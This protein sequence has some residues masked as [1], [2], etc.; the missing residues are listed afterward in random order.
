MKFS[1]RSAAGFSPS[2][3]AAR[4]TSR[5]MTYAAS[6]RFERAADLLRGPRED[7]LFGIDEDLGTESPADIRRDDAEL[8]L[9]DAEDEGAHDEPMD[10]RVLR[11]HPQCQVL[12]RLVIARERRA[13]LHRDGGEALIGETLPNDLPGGA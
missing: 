7:T 11:G 10:V 13:R 8:V 9:G 5:S 4:S 12:R 2:W 6:G 3:C 1:R